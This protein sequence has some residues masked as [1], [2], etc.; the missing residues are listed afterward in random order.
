MLTKYVGKNCIIYVVVHDSQ[1]IA[2]KAEL[3]FSGTFAFAMIKLLHFFTLLTSRCPLL[4]HRFPPPTSANS[5]MKIGVDPHLESTLVSKSIRNSWTLSLPTEARWPPW[6]L[7]ELLLSK[8]KVM[9]L[10]KATWYTTCKI[11]LHPTKTFLF[12]SACSICPRTWKI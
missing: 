12:C 3:A 8:K 6:Y 11:F 7:E 1:Y 9:R 2:F 5:K 10:I 4:L